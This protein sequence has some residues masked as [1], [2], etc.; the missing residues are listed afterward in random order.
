MFNNKINAFRKIEIIGSKISS[1]PSIIAKD[2][3]IEGTLSSEGEVE[4]E[5]SVKGVINSKSVIIR[6]TGIVDGEIFA[7]HLSIKGKFRGKIISDN[8]NISSKG[9]I[10][11]EIEYQTLNVEDGA[12]IDGKFKKIKNS[13]SEN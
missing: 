5:G 3:K 2:L 7:S 1:M 9:D 11:G 4:I 13:N 6:E 12:C 10:E 8:I